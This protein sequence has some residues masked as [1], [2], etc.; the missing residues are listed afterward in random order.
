MLF[1]LSITLI[2][3]PQQTF[4][5]ESSC[6]EKTIDFKNLKWKSF[7]DYELDGQNIIQLNREDY[8]NESYEFIFYSKIQR[9]TITVLIKRTNMRTKMR[10]L[11][12]LSYKDI[13]HLK[14]LDLFKL[15]VSSVK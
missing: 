9:K 7:Y 8:R 14:M 6:K 15:F 10:Q 13:E 4:C 3:L 12:K 5:M 2:F 1:L 11:T